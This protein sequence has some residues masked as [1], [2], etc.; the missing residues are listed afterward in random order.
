MEMSFSE[1]YAKPSI[2]EIVEKTNG[3][4]RTGNLGDADHDCVIE[5]FGESKGSA[6]NSFSIIETI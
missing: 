2:K 6:I 4:A 1:F 3:G 5:A